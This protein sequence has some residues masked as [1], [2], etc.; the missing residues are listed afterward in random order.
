[1]S[2][3]SWFASRKGPGARTQP[4]ARLAVEALEERCM[5]SAGPGAIPAPIPTP[6]Y[7][8]AAASVNALPKNNAPVVFLGDSITDLYQFSP[9]W[10][11][12]IAP[13]GA[14]DLG[15]PGNSTQ[16]VLYQL[17]TGVLRGTAPRVVVLMI[18]INNLQSFQTPEQTAEGVAAC[19]S[20]IRSL[21]P[22][23]RILLLG[24]L[25]AYRTA[26]LGI[27][28]QIIQTNQ[29]IAGLDDGASVRFL[30]IGANFLQP[31]GS[32]S[33]AVMADYG[34][35]TALGYAIETNAILPTLFE[36]FQPVVVSVSPNGTLL[37]SDA[38]GV[39]QLFSGVR[40]ASVASGPRGE[41]L[42]VVFQDGTLTQFDATGAHPLFGGVA[43]AR[44]AFGPFGEVLDVVFAGGHALEISAQGVHSLA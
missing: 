38:L 25:P 30:D 44:V 27:R 19:V 13:L 40:S 3:R 2:F 23:S 29:S 36:L 17:D 33:S 24:V 22:Q 32:I 12:Q 39:H 28:Q 34:H 11:A 16:N 14:V 15:I 42:D 43:A 5:L 6:G 8:A 4:V 35:P 26:D 31:D 10:A 18:G 21:E 1:M 9:S 37:Q 41:V 7:L 20:T